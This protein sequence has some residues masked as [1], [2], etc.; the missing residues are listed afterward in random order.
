MH[1]EGISMGKR[2]CG[3]WLLSAIAVCQLTGCE[4]ADL[5]SAWQAQDMAIRPSIQPG[6]SDWAG[7]MSQ[8]EDGK[9]SL[10]VSNNGEFLYL[11][12]AVNDLEGDVY[13]QYAQVL[14]TNGLTIWL[15]PNG[16]DEKF[17][18]IR[19]LASNARGSDDLQFIEPKGQEFFT[20][21]EVL[22]G[23][24]FNAAA[25]YSENHY[26]CVIKIPL[27]DKNQNFFPAAFA[28]SKAIGVNF[29]GV[30]TDARSGAKHH[31]GRHGE[32][33]Q[34]NNATPVPT[35]IPSGFN[36]SGVNGA[37]PASVSPNAGGGNDE[38]AD[39][40]DLLSVGVRVDLASGQSPVTSSP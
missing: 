20:S 1:H 36:G 23:Y 28:A 4:T 8:F 22:G 25:S 33:A 3:F 12:L 5:K 2:P 30:E 17:F 16:G 34:T 32:T 15:D 6:I 14:E 24:G 10:G 38:S 40:S 27:K 26:S 37:N 29:E 19:F 21:A 39:N 13:T 7:P 31:G 18:G 11:A 35:P 9:V